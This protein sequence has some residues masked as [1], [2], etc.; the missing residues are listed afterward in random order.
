[1]LE[2]FVTVNRDLIVARAKLRVAGRMSPK[3]NDVELKNGVP[4]FLDQLST[5][6]QMA[7]STSQDVAH[8]QISQSAA[9]HG[10]D[11][12][13]MGL[14][15]DQVVRDYG[16]VCQVITELAIEQE[17]NISRDEFQTLNLCLDDAIA[18]AV[19][20]F[21][22]QRERTLT[23]QGTERLGVL[24]HEMRTVLT[25]ALLTFESIRTGRVATGGSTGL[26]L[27]RSLMSLR[28]LLDRSLADVRLDAGIEQLERI[29][30]A[31]FL[32]EVEIGARMQAE[33]RG[34]QLAVTSVDRAA[35]VEG[36]RQILAAVLANLLQNAFKFTH[37][38]GTVSLKTLTTADRVLFE[39]EDECGGLP[40]GKTED[41]FRPFEQRGRD[42]SGVGLGL[43]ICLKAAKAL[44]GELRVRDLPGKGCVF[45]LDL[46]RQPPP[47]LTLIEG[48]KGSV[49][50]APAADGGKAPKPNRKSPGRTG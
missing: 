14:T 11:L 20:A 40:P 48:G 47:P 29:P 33:A 18:G 28:D 46:P 15:I 12:F 21:A 5:A 17:S 43:S 42:R 49:R 38:H 44:A 7:G 24:A 25:T 8:E 4:V 37:P 30:V 41:L 27:G 16:D 31:E 1:M 9:E 6:L 26:M 36:D 39:V 50:P 35:V 13:R 3:P 2:E 32:E 34:I 22:S 19:T 10:G 45:T 23:N